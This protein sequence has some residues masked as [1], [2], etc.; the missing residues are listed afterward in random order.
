MATLK[1]A[2]EGDAALMLW[3]D[4][5][6]LSLSKRASKAQSS[7]LRVSFAVPSIQAKTVKSMRSLPTDGQQKAGVRE[8]NCLSIG[9]RTWV[10][11]LNREFCDP[12]EREIAEEHATHRDSPVVRESES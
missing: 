6:A 8:K 4:S 7:V 9:L 2:L 5:R 12:D 1:W 10:V 3:R 11:E